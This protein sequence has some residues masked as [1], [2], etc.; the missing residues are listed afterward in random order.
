MG[1]PALRAVKAGPSGRPEGVLRSL[2]SPG[3]AATLGNCQGRGENCG[4]W[5]GDQVSIP[6]SSAV[7]TPVFGMGTGVWPPKRGSGEYP[8]TP[9]RNVALRA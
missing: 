5:L 1:G 6:L 4:L 8:S 2:D 7:F 9:R 3:R